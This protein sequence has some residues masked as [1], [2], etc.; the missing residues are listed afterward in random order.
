MSGLTGTS[1]AQGIGANFTSALAARLEEAS[2]QDQ[3]LTCANLA[4]VLA[5]LYT[6]GLLPASTMYSFLDHLTQR[7]D[8]SN[9]KRVT[10]K[11]HVLAAMPIRSELMTQEAHCSFE[12]GSWC[13]LL[14]LA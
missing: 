10:R 11:P 13:C 9:A 14:A 3:S 6:C 8:F 12:D 4:S 1:D 5:H 7:C 2:Q